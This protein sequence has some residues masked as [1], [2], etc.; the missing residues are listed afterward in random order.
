MGGGLKF[1]NLKGWHP[2]NKAN[3]KR[4]W[5][6]EQK[7][8]AK[9]E[10][11]KEAAS[12]LRKN[13]ELYRFQKI[14]AAKGDERSVTQLASQS[15]EFMYAPPP[16]L[17]KIDKSV[18]SDM[19]EDDAVREFRRR[20]EKKTKTHKNEQ[21]KKTQRK[22]ERYVGRRP[23]ESLTIDEQVERF[24]FLKDAPVEGDYT[25]NVKVNFKPMGV[26]LRNVRCLRC[27]EWGHLSG[28][29]E[30]ELRN[31]NPHDAARQALEDPFSYMNKM[32][33]VNKQELVLRRAAIPF[34]MQT[35][36]IS[37]DYELIS[38]EDDS[39]CDSESAFLQKL[40]TKE[41]KMLLKKLKKASKK[42]KQEKSK[43]EDRPAR[44]QTKSDRAKDSGDATRRHRR[45]S[46][47][48]YF[49][50]KRTRHHHSRSTSRPRSR[51]L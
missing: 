11:E 5:I 29:R 7:E 20:M 38:S 50:R 22:L 23:D 4:I 45:R 6:A 34:E 39:D 17:Q 41:K 44:K 31:F 16:G 47:S 19:R 18:E 48:S 43:D 35:E 51:R 14:A 26:Q 30:C 37:K 32:T 25:G 15:V 8:K 1:L 3:Q 42:E 12:E 21:A 27:G 10:R 40:T 9:E 49:S 2:S 28:D 24:P 46:R 36:H 13:A 33:Q